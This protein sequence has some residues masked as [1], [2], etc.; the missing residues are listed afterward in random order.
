[1]AK[2]GSENASSGGRIQS[3]QVFGFEIVLSQIQN[4][5][6]FADDECF[7]RK[8]VTEQLFFDFAIES[9]IFFDVLE[10]II[11]SSFNENVLISCLTSR[12]YLFDL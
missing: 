4:L 2:I 3:D 1:M 10:E 5:D 8:Y 11:K 9:V 12:V 7:L 6:Q